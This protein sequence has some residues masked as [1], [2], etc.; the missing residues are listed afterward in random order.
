MTL[1]QKITASFLIVGL[2]VENSNK[3]GREG[4]SEYE[5][6]ELGSSS[7]AFTS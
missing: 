1:P 4:E 2:A 3:S 5:E 7:S 6:K